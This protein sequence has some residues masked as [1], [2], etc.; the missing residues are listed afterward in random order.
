[1]NDWNTL[2]WEVMWV[3]KVVNIER[4]APLPIE[5]WPEDEFTAPRWNSEKGCYEVMLTNKTWEPH[6]GNIW[7]M[8]P[9]DAFI[10]SEIQVIA[11]KISPKLS[12]DLMEDLKSVVD[13]AGKWCIKD[14]FDKDHNSR[15]KFWGDHPSIDSY[16]NWV[17]KMKWNKLDNELG[18]GVHFLKET[19]LSLL[20]TS[21]YKILAREAPALMNLWQQSQDY[22]TKNFS[23]KV[24][25]LQQ[26]DLEIYIFIKYLQKAL[27]QQ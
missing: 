15:R 4:I 12:N 10:L 1:M 9:P 19:L 20:S 23:D 14:H 3:E 7:E 11:E 27:N 6:A 8:Y 5:G 22:Q 2:P 24:A 21:D 17:S 25:F 18:Q 13:F 16:C 26:L